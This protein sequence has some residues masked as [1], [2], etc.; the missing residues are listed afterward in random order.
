MRRRQLKKLWARLKE[1][2]QM[3]PARD[4]LLLKLGA[5][6]SQYTSAWRLVKVKV[7]QEED[8]TFSLRKDNR[9][10][11][12]R[13]ECRYLL[14]YTLGVENPARLWQLY[15]LLTQIEE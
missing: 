10:K 9:R 6:K 15:V 11:I 14:R 12:R 8:L 2:Q 5:A 4:T 7:C 3:A 13:R 1:L